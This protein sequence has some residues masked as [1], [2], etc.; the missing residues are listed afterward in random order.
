MLFD[1][2]KV[3]L[4]YPNYTDRADCTLSGGSWATTLPLNNLKN[5]VIQRR[6]RTTD[7]Q[8]TSTQ[9]SITLDDPKPVLCLA[10]AGHNLT[11]QATI[12]IKVYDNPLKETLL[13]E[14]G[15]E[16]GWA[17]IF[18]SNDLEW[19]Y[20]NFW[21]GTLTN[22]QR[23]DFTPLFTHFF[24]GVDFVPIAKHIIVEI[25]DVDNPDGYVEIGRLFFSDVWQPTRNASLGLAFKHNTSTEVETSLSDTEYFDVRKVRRSVSFELDRIPNADA[26]GRM[27][28]LQRL[29]GINGEILFAYTVRNFEEWSYE[30]RFLGRLIELDAISE[31][32]V[33]RRHKVPVNIIESI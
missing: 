20:D 31:P 6:A 29:L 15:E 30:R 16:L 1:P 21:F 27:F 8:L 2:D 18:D 7:T 33:D 17:Y 9:F 10:L 11:A 3:A 24:L 32:Y 5:R 26:F 25:N 23:K 22:E 12:K 28:A 14:S 19:E 13:Y 4:C